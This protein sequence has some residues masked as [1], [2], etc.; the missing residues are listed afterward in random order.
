MFPGPVLINCSYSLCKGGKR[1]RRKKKKRTQHRGI[2]PRLKSV[3]K[4]ARAIE[5]KEEERQTV[6]NKYSA[7][8]SEVRETQKVDKGHRDCWHSENTKLN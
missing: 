8:D 5:R 7:S 1:K 2:Y 4:Q 3:P 6:N